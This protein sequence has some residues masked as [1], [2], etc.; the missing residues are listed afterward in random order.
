MRRR[1]VAT[2]EARMGSTRLPGK[3]ALELYPDLPALGAVIERLGTCK[4]LDEIVVA[5]S[6]DS[7][8]DTVVDIAKRFDAAY[9][10]G[11]E[12]DV[13][14]RVVG[15][16]KK[17]EASVVVLVTGD[18]SCISFSLIDEGVEFFLKNGYA[19]VSNCL[20]EGYPVGIDLQV[21]HMDAL[22]KADAM[23]HKKP[24]CDDSNNFE[25]TNF[26][27]SNHPELFSIYQYPVPEKY[28]QPHIQLALDTA[29][30]LQVLRNIYARLY[31]KNHFF[32]IDDILALLEREP[33][34]LRSVNGS[35]ANG[36]GY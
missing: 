28:N 13:L 19:F 30:D 24:Y 8:D 1:V 5:T 33:D 22:A 12:D 3:M 34:I 15:A 6:Q 2:I 17:V 29:A 7:V 21:V 9:F 20:T 11:S 36:L 18:C 14:R 4:T 32:D 31:P 26:F 10:R 23:A 25:H 16:A 35:N 27:I